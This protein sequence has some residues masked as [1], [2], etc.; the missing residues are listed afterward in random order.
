MAAEFYSREYA[1]FTDGTL[2]SISGPPACLGHLMDAVDGAKKRSIIQLLAGQ[3]SPIF[4]K[5]LMDAQLT[6]RLTAEYLTHSPTSLVADAVESLS[7][8]PLLHMIHTKDGVTAACMVVAY[9]TAKERKKILKAFKGHVRA[10]AKDEWGTLALIT[11]LSV[12]DDTS[13]SKKSIV[14]ELQVCMYSLF[15]FLG[16]YDYDVFQ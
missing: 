9:S 8:E 11:A 10:A 4:E 3:L 12:V 15:H 14:N 2:N 6:H 7:G 1:L 13:L 5:G 16:F